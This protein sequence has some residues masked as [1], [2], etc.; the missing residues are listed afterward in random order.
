M[1]DSKRHILLTNESGV[2]LVSEEAQTTDY[3]DTESISAV[4]R[5]NKTVIVP[6]VQSMQNYIE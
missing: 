6:R 5:R 1:L 4:S 3:L 2:S